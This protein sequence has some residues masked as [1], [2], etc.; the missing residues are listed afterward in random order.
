MGEVIEV[1]CSH[2]HEW[3]ISS[4]RQEFW[5]PKFI[6]I[7]GIIGRS[8]D[9]MEKFGESY[10]RVLHIFFY[11]QHVYKHARLSFLEKLSTLLSTPSGSVWLEAT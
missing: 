6:V 7:P 2:E 9:G 3:G 4:F 5:G 10:Q 11:K 8:E 1:Q